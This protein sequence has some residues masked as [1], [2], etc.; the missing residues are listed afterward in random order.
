MAVVSRGD[1]GGAFVKVP[2][3][4]LK[5]FGFLGIDVGLEMVKGVELRFLGY[6]SE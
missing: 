3:H 5:T 2:P 1:G 4:P 6:A